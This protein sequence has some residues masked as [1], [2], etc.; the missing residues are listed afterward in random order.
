VTGV[1]PCVRRYYASACDDARR[2]IE[3]GAPDPATLPGTRL[4]VESWQPREPHRYAKTP[5]W[6]A[7]MI[8]ETLAADAEKREKC[9]G[10]SW[11]VGGGQWLSACGYCDAYTLTDQ[12]MPAYATTGP[13]MVAEH[14][15]KVPGINVG[16]LP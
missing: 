11:H 14:G 16:L 4:R 13:H 3:D 8:L 15:A 7:R 6:D 1:E 10:R 12:A 9:A 2:A 5:A